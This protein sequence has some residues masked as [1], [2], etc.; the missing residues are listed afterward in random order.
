M[1][2]VIGL[3][4]ELGMR[5][6]S[7]EPPARPCPAS[8]ETGSGGRSPRGAPTSPTRPTGDRLQ[9]FGGPPRIA[10]QGGH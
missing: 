1:E 6:P 8:S 4:S 10:H 9:S 3:S 7:Q 2:R 5:R